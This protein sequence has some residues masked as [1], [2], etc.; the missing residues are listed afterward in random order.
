MSTIQQ[1]G[2]KESVIWPPRGFPA[3]QP[4][5]PNAQRF[6]DILRMKSAVPALALPT[7]TK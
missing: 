1:W 5:M 4:R 6:F 3:S 2:R 7:H